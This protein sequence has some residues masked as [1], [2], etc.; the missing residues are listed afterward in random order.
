MIKNHIQVLVFARAREF[1]ARCPHHSDSL[2]RLIEP[3]DG[4]FVSGLHSRHEGRLD[5][6]HYATPKISVHLEVYIQGLVLVL[7]DGH[8]LY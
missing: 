6:D 5:H 7:V 1:K 8:T 2:K 4:F 3:L